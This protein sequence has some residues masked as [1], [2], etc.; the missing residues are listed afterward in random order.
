MTLFSEFDFIL[1][2]KIFLVSVEIDFKVSMPETL[3]EL[4]FYRFFIFGTGIFAHFKSHLHRTLLLR[5]YQQSNK[6][7]I[8]ILNKKNLKFFY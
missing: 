7:W 6:T 2:L 3:S 8:M 1:I 4:D 5:Q